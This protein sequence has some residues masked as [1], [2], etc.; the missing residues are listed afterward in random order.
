MEDFLDYRGIKTALPANVVTMYQYLYR[1]REPNQ[2]L[3]GEEALDCVMDA[4][5]CRTSD[6]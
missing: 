2:R 6:P 4:N 1:Y 3:T 5:R